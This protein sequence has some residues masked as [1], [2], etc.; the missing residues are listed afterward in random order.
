MKK[1]HGSFRLA[2]L[3][4]DDLYIILASLRNV[5]YK[6]ICTSIADLTGVQAGVH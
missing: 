4:K 5:Y 2:G 1:K 3:V 6:E